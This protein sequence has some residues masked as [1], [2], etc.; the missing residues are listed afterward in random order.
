MQTFLFSDIEGSTR[1]WEEHPEQMAPA[2]AR[3]DG[4]L[5]GAVGRAGGQVIKATGD[6]ILARF[7]TA[8]DAL[9]AA[10]DAQKSLASEPWGMV[11]SLKVRMGI[12]TGE[13]EQRGGDYFGPTMNRTARIMAAGH[14]GQVLFS[15]MAA[16]LVDDRLPHGA[17]L[18][19]LGIH[20]LKD[21]TQP[22]HLFQLVHDELE[23]QFPA[24]TTLDSRPHN[25]PLQAT[26][27]FGR[28]AE[29]S[30]IDAMLRSPGTKLVTIVGPGGAGKTRLGL[31]V[32]A[33]Q[34]E[35]FAD[36]VFFVDL[37][38]ERAPDAAYEAIVR[39][40]AL[41][42]TGG[43]DP[44]QILR[45]RLRD[46]SMLLVLDN[47]EQV[48]AAALGVSELLNHSPG[49]KVIV[50]SRETLRVRAEHV[51]PVPPLSLPHPKHS[52]AEIAASESVQ[53]FVE[54]A[55]AVRPDFVISDE[56]A[57]V[58]AEICNRLDGLPLAIELAAARLNVFTPADLLSRLRTRLD[59]LGAGGR[60]LPDRQRTLWGAIAW[61]YELLDEKERDV[62]ELM[63]VFSPT[64]LV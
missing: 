22:E 43:G 41:S 50:T 17:A 3:H 25:L 21:L 10:V 35:R 7:D 23:S 5:T 62:F 42:V 30:T 59:V 53:L 28:S 1:L 14:G 55:V 33:E 20:R 58:I 40:L 27:F 13:S 18:R 9:A 34:I 64:R 24:L 51:F 15:A 16:R 39:A 29:I 54:R 49:L 56:N 4:I 36:G 38:A 52:T 6:G 19:D 32:A 26:E 48:T 2:L 37:S 61:S 45:S 31:Q 8:P 57:R 46:K 60:D 12:H 47:F 63:A 44:L 11:G